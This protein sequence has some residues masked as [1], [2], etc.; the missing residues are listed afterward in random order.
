[1]SRSLCGSTMLTEI[2]LPRARLDNRGSASPMW[3]RYLAE[4]AWEYSQ[5]TFGLGEKGCVLGCREASQMW[6]HT[7]KWGT[8][9][10]L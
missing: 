6:K 3:F 1:M 8:Q 5:D 7:A 2:G 9:F 10:D 4:L